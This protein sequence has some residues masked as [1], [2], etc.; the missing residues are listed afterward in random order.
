[1]LSRADGFRR[2]HRLGQPPRDQGGQRWFHLYPDN[3]PPAGDPAHWTGR[4]QTWNYQCAACHSTNLQKNYD[5]L[6]NSYK[7]SW[8]D[9]DVACEACH[10]PGSV[11]WLGRV[12]RRPETSEWD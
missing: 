8:T 1:L 3:P 4:D 6:G 5:A 11:T 7:T 12:S 9:V 2:W 10:G